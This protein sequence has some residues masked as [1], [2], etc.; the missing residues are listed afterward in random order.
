MSRNL[1]K[2]KLAFLNEFRNSKYEFQYIKNLKEIKKVQNETVWD[3]D[4]IFKDTMGRLTFHIVDE[5]Q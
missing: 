4:Q 1:E 5:K 3:F 2:I